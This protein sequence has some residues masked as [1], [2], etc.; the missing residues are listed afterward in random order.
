[1][2]SSNCQVYIHVNVFV[3]FVFSA[4]GLVMGRLT[5]N[6]SR[7][8]LAGLESFR[9]KPSQD[10][11]TRRIGNVVFWCLGVVKEV[12]LLNQSCD[13][14]WSGKGYG[15]TWTIVTN[16]GGLKPPFGWCRIYFH[17]GSWSWWTWSES[18]VPALISIC[19]AIYVK[20][21]VNQKFMIFQ[22]LAEPWSSLN[23]DGRNIVYRAYVGPCRNLKPEPILESTLYT[24]RLF[25]FHLIPTF[26]FWRISSKQC[27]YSEA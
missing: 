25:V 3:T 15:V 10:L 8:H 23:L 19:F 12:G 18:M 6:H 11:A 7:G 13:S 26:M 22:R 20:A 1:M 24:A 9:D 17:N 16:S 27:F 2:C 21:G 4:K 14:K 5:L